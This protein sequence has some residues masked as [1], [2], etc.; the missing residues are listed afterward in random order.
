MYENNLQDYKVKK[1]KIKR[2]LNT[3]KSIKTWNNDVKMKK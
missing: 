3:K 1:K 2:S